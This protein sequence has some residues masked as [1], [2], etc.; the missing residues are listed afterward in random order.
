MARKRKSDRQLR[1]ELDS[2]TERLRQARTAEA[3]TRGWSLWGFIRQHKNSLTSEIARAKIDELLAFATGEAYN[4]L[5]EALALAESRNTR[6]KAAEK[7]AAKANRVVTTWKNRAA[8]AENALGTS[9]RKLEHA[10][11]SLALHG[12]AVPKRTRKI[13]GDQNSDPPGQAA[14]Q[15]RGAAGE[16]EGNRRGPEKALATT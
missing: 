2:I 8:A 6:A 9:Q 3:K 5:A 1:K 7:A 13:S 4:K 12:L 11:K 14:D 16:L 15:R 10:Y